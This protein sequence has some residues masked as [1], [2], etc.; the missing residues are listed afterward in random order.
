MTAVTTVLIVPTTTFSEGV[1]RGSPAGRQA[2][3]VQG[4]GGQ[5]LPLGTTCTEGDLVHWGLTAPVSRPCSSQHLSLGSRHR[6][7]CK[8]RQKGICDVI[9]IISVILCIL[10][11]P[12]GLIFS[13]RPQN[14]PVRT[15]QLTFYFLFFAIYIWFFF[16]NSFHFSADISTCLC[17]IPTFL[18]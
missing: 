12:V 14:K 18:L 15:E 16:F 2:G 9:I 4:A 3:A 7:S 8:A 11:H 13:Y 1:P 17:I 10:K 5:L 6:I